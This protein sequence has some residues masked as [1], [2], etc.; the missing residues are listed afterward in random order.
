MY[1]VIKNL[2]ILSNLELYQRL[3]SDSS[4]NLILDDRY[5]TSIRR[6]LDGSNRYDIILPLIWTYNSI[7]NWLE[8]PRIFHNDLEYKSFIN[9]IEQMNQLIKSSIE[10][11][12][13]LCNTYNFS[14]ISLNKFVYWLNTKFKNN[15]SNSPVIYPHN[16]IFNINYGLY[17]YWLNRF[18]LPQ[19]RNRHISYHIQY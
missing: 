17:Y 3:Y 15:L 9:K 13:I 5:F 12:K 11:L 16:S 1:I 8:I 4:N 19:T 14:F 7:L 6:Y 2:T 10:G 18:L